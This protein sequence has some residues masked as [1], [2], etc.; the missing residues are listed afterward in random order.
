MKWHIMAALV[1]CSALFSCANE[2][3][4]QD[5][6]QASSAPAP[7]EIVTNVMDFVMPDTIEA[8]WST[9]RYINKSNEP[10]FFIF[11]KYPEGKTLDTA[12]LVAI[13]PFQEGMNKIMEGRPEEAGAEF[14]K[15]P[16]WFAEVQFF[17]GSG[18]VSPGK[19]STTTV[20]LDPGYY[21]IECYM[22]MEGGI[23]HSSV[24]ML[25]EL[26]VIESDSSNNKPDIK[27]NAKIEISGVEGIEV[28]DTLPAGE[29]TFEVFFKDQKLHENYSGHDIN[30]A[31]VSENADLR[32]LETWM[33]WAEPGGLL[34]LP[35]DGVTFLGGFNNMAAEK[36]GYF[37]VN[38]E[39]GKKYIL[40][41]E[42]P[43]TIE[44]NMMKEIVVVE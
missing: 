10:H 36:T 8:G 34:K 18:I 9:F 2:K 14:A 13:P 3:D 29:T 19:T 41:S 44:K 37:T 4:I 31:E 32:A 16:S 40:V 26:H 24:G 5:Q 12:K 33:N 11:E 35:P 22:K 21:F 27:S 17:G 6:E 28:E 25:E 39:A 1:V 7:I 30:I 42:V 38:L 15:L 43:N 20:Q 23:F